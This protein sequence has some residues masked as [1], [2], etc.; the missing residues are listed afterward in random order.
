[1]SEPATPLAVANRRL[2]YKLGG[3]AV[4]A[5]GFG[6]ALAPLYDVFCQLTGINGKVEQF[7][8]PPS[9]MK[10]DRSRSVQVR[11]LSQPM[12][13]MPIEFHPSQSSLSIHPGDIILARYWVRN[14]TDTPLAGNAVPSISPGA[15]NAYFKKIDCFCFRE[16]TLAPGEERELAVTFWVDS[17]LPKSIT[18][19]TLSYAFYGAVKK[20]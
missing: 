9:Q 13:G 19:I 14:P 12:P 11:F 18:D 1:M 16:Q 7:N 6:F 10:V 20:S 2:A 5:L 8:L 17:A 4:L 15:A 3:V